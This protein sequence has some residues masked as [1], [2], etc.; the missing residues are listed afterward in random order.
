MD[1]A[2]QAWGGGFYLLSK[3]FLSYSEGCEDD[4]R[5]RL[6]GWMLYLIGVPAWVII[7]A[8]K[9][10]WIATSIEIGGIPA[11]IF[12]IIVSIKGLQQMPNLSKKMV[13]LF[14][15]SLLTIGVS[16]SLY[17]HNGISSISQIMEIGSM[18]G[19]LIGTNLLAK[20]KST[21]WLWFM[22]MNVCMGM[23]MVIQN[24]P[25]LAVQ[26]AISLCFVIYGY[27]VSKNN[28]KG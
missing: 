18:A 3:M 26:Q 9:H 22:I 7:L 2:L 5:L 15:Y 17:D 24:K 11:I 25:I 16:Y 6:L 12:G 23:L 20:K 1:F 28:V 27:I 19:F 21:G 14:A 13:E 10:S 8:S 4:K